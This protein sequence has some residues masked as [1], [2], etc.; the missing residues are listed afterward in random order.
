MADIIVKGMD[1]PKT[2]CDCPLTYYSDQEGDLCC[3][4]SDVV[5]L[6]IGRQGDCPLVAIPE[7]HG[8][9]GDLDALEKE[10]EFDY[11]YAAAKVC[12]DAPTVIPAE[13]G[14]GRCLTS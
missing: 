11:A 8:R 12:H 14:D 7:G 5:C 13:R 6:C 1:M 3:I 4:F 2:C 10:L 9:L